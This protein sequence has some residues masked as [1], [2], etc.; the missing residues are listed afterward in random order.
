MPRQAL[1]MQSR[2]RLL[3]IPPRQVQ[4]AAK[5]KVTVKGHGGGEDPVAGGAGGGGVPG[6]AE[7]Q[8]GGGAQGDDHDIDGDELG[9]DEVPLQAVKGAAGG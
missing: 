9:Q 6:G 2:A 5:A 3:P 4:A 1:V 7:G 8:G